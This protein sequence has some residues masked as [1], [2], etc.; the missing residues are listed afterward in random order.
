[1]FLPPGGIIKPRKQRA[2]PIGGKWSEEED[3]ALTAIV[4]QTGPKNWKKVSI[5]FYLF[6][7]LV[8]DYLCL[9]LCKYTDIRTLGSHE[10]R[11]AMPS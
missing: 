3:R 2:A 9:F 4:Q 6:K 1:M 10:N 8:V 7:I 11:C 5:S